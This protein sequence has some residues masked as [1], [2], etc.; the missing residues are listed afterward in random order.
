MLTVRIIR[1]CSFTILQLLPDPT[2]NWERIMRGARET[3]AWKRDGS[4]WAMQ[5]E[6]S[7]T[8]WSSVRRD[9]RLPS[10]DH[11]VFRTL[12][13][14]PCVLNIEVGVRD[15]GTLLRWNATDFSA[16]IS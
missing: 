1:A 7:R 6:V 11:V 12:S 3:Y 10:L 5:A 2:S 8:N 9:F 4:G 15:D 13:S 16:N 14:S